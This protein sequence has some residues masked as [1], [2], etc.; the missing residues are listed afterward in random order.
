M[1]P[2]SLSTHVSSR[3][4]VL[5][6]VCLVP[7][8][9]CPPEMHFLSSTSLDCAFILQWAFTPLIFLNVF[10]YNCPM[11]VLAFASPL[12]VFIGYKVFYMLPMGVWALC[13][14]YNWQ[15]RAVSFEH[16]WKTYWSNQETPG[17]S[18]NEGHPTF[19]PLVGWR[20]EEKEGQCQSTFDSLN[21][22]Q[23]YYS[24]TQKPKLKLINKEELGEE[25]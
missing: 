13:F 24:P 18:E 11:A 10:F 15:G 3:A 9:H 23:S 19:L 2:E 5:I 8:P 21:T 17:H 4:R 20:V 22:G 7:K 14:E 16:R 1:H 6:Q 12:C 25:F